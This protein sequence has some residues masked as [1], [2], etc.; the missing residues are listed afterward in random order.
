MNRAWL[1]VLFALALAGCDHKG[2]DKGHD[3]GHDHGAAPPSAAAP[4]ASAASAT[5]LP[6]PK[7]PVQ[8]EMR[9]L[10]EAAR[11]SVSAIANN[12]LSEIPPALHR[13]HSA[14]E[15]TEKALE[16]G[17]YKPPKNPDKVADLKSTDEA[18]HGEL[19]KLMRAANANDL[20]GATKQFGV[21][22]EGCT[23]CH[24]K[25]RF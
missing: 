2:H 9:A 24:Q 19:V 22:L 3:H 23:S 17:D 25:F 16:K 12:R 5:A 10:E 13:V 21:V 18:F 4:G 20:P 15:A 11:I 1:P 6:P 8:A 14:M 7:N